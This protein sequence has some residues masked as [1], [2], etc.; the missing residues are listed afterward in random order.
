MNGID[1]TIIIAYL[2]AMVGVGMWFM[3][4]NKSADDYSRGGGRLPWWVVSLSI[5][6]TLFSSITFLSVP[7]L[8]YHTDCRYFFKTFAI[9]ILVP[10]VV[11][12]YLPFFRKLNLTSAYGYLEVRF[13]LGCCG[14]GAV[15]C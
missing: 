11:K 9:L 15:V 14:K 10:I 8:A 1:A 6:A 2:L 12:F 5:Y 7:A 4:R 3:H 13:N